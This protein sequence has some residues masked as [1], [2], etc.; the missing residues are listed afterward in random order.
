MGELFAP[1]ECGGNMQSLEDRFTG[2]RFTRH[3]IYRCKIL[4]PHHR[5]FEPPRSNREYKH[6]RV[7]IYLGTLTTLPAT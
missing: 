2:Y 1:V 6:S 4:S 3:I 5:Q 7:S